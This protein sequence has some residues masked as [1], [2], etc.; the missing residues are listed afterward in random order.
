MKISTILLQFILLLIVS[1]VAF[2][3]NLVFIKEMNLNLEKP[4]NIGFVDEDTFFIKE[5]QNN[6]IK[7]SNLNNNSLLQQFDVDVFAFDSTKSKLAIGQSNQ[8][9]IYD[10][11]NFSVINT[12]TLEPVALAD[13]ALSRD[14]NQLALASQMS[15]EV[16]KVH[17]YNLLNNQ[18]I[19]TLEIQQSNILEVKFVNDNELLIASST[20][21]SIWGIDSGVLVNTISPPT[22]SEAK[23]DLTSDDGKMLIDGRGFASLYDIT[24]QNEIKLFNFL[25]VIPTSVLFSPNNQFAL[26]GFS[27]GYIRIFDLRKENIP[28]IFSMKIHSQDVISIDFSTN[29]NR[30]LT[31]DSEGTARLWQFNQTSSTQEWKNYQ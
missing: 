8:I 31:L 9:N 4:E 5:N 7:V 10:T 1:N 28:N 23:I 2:S 25:P 27:D 24:N 16:V 19:N 12:L 13:I 21:I 11:Q 14:G 30:L 15:E 26:F 6:T 3:Q 20:D 22:R 29:G 17:I 18:Q